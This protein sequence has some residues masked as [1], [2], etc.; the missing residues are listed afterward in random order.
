MS[1]LKV[2][3]GDSSRIGTDVT[4]F[5]DGCIYFAHD[6]GAVYIDT[7]VDGEQKRV[8]IN[9]DTTASRTVTATLEYSGWVDGA[10]TIT[11]EGLSAGDNGFITVGANATTAE[12]EAVKD[13]YLRCVDNGDGTL[14]II[15]D[16][17]VPTCDIPVI[18]TIF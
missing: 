11:V 17:V 8:R 9:P 14:T 16:G 18:I 13:A 2:L 1:Q 10:Q 15:A 4:P 7:V 6:T 5:D 3:R 12:V